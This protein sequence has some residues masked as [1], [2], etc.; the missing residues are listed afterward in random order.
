MIFGMAFDEA[1]ISGT[2]REP[3]RISWI[4]PRN[5]QAMISRSL[6]AS[7]SPA[8]SCAPPREPKLGRV[9]LRQT[10]HPTHLEIL[11]PQLIPGAHSQRPNQER[12]LTSS[13]P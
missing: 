13:L 2:A 7:A 9:S 8:K 5:I 3:D 11:H 10:A 12:P 4:S 1:L 6:K